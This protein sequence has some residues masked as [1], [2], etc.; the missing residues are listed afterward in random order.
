MERRHCIVIVIPCFLLTL[1]MRREY[2][3]IRYSTKKAPTVQADVEILLI[4]A[5]GTAFEA[6]SNKTIA[7]P[8]GCGLEV[9][10]IA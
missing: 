5:E 1:I 10:L 3:K 9:A 8:R 7:S 4:K 2:G 6:Q